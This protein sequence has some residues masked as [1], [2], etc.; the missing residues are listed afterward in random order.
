MPASPVTYPLGPPTI[1]G[2]LITVDMALADPTIITRDIARLTDQKFFASRVFADAGTVNGGAI[3]Y[4]TPPTTATDLFAERGFQ[5]VAPGEEHPIL[6]FLRGVPVVAKPRKIGGKWPVTK[7]AAKRNDTRLVSRAMAQTANTLALTLD[8][9]AIAVLNAAITANSRTTAGQS[10]ATAAGLT[11][12]NVSGTNQAVSDILS[13]QKVLETE[14]RGHQVDSILIHPNQHLSLVQAA[15]RM[16]TTIDTIF[17]A[18]GIRNWFSSMRVPAGTAI[19]YEEGMVGGW[20]NEFPLS[21]DAWYDKD[22]EQTWYKWNISP[23]MFIDDWY[24]LM[25][26]TGIA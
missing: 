25:Q 11:T 7:E 1:S 26:L 10:W 3:L 5:E 17:E 20:A 4:E 15:I 8:A 12:L 22:E 14:Q 9:M 19:L 2:N 21:Q 6:T 16:G 24:G 18:A 13:V 23:C